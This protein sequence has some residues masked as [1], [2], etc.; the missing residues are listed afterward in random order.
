LQHPYS[1]PE[2]KKEKKYKKLFIMT[3]NRTR[4][5]L[6]GITSV[7]GSEHHAIGIIH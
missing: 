1:Y 5:P 2:Q 7:S 3:L 6:F 4:T